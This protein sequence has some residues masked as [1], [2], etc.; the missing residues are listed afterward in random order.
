MSGW[1]KSERN[2]LL[3]Y[4]FY[5]VHYILVSHELVSEICICRWASFGVVI[6]RGGL[7]TKVVSDRPTRT[8]HPAL[9]RTMGQSILYP[10]QVKVVMHQAFL[11]ILKKCWS[12]LPSSSSWPRVL[13]KVNNG[14]HDST[15]ASTV[16]GV[17]KYEVLYVSDSMVMML[18][19]KK[20]VESEVVVTK[21]MEVFVGT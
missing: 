12:S 10:H 16:D 4:L 9:V 3:V 13:A 1:P 14:R 8:S 6:S 21:N 5:T 17:L 15:Y 19:L 7:T 2:K 20:N 18:R 11:N